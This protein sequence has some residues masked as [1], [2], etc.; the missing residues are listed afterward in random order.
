MLIMKG[1]LSKIVR[2]CLWVPVFIV[3]L[4]LINKLLDS[5]LMFLRVTLRREI[6]V[7]L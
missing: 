4:I 2:M 1:G 3:R 6:V 7:R 5:F